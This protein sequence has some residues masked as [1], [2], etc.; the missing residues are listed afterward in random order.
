MKRRSCGVLRPLERN[1]N[2]GNEARCLFVD[3]AE[4]ELIRKP[5]MLQNV[6]FLPGAHLAEHCAARTGVE[7]F[8]VLPGIVSGRGFWRAFLRQNR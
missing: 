1:G 7:R 6:L 8:F 4:G 5:L 3:D 2:D